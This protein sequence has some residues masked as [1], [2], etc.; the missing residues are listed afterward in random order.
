MTR[1]GKY[2]LAIWEE[3]RARFTRMPSSPIGNCVS[4]TVPAIEWRRE[5][6]TRCFA[7]LHKSGR[8]H[9]GQSFLRSDRSGPQ[10]GSDGFAPDADRGL[11]PWPDGDIEHT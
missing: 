4:D 1:W 5:G 7:R 10:H 8:D 3:C 6:T 9:R 2:S 11:W